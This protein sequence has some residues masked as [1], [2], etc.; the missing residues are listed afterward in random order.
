MELYFTMLKNIPYI[1]AQILFT[2]NRYGLRSAESGLVVSAFDIGSLIVVIFI[3]YFGGQGHRARWVG[4]GAIF[5]A[6]GMF[7]L[8]IINA[9]AIQLVVTN[10]L[11]IIL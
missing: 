1:V 2:D 6:I 8:E 5:V 9:F 10:L 4:V 3:S 7:G 11:V